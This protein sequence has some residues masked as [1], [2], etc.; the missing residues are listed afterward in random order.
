MRFCLADACD[1]LS[2]YCPVGAIGLGEAVEA[3]LNLDEF[4]R[5]GRYDFT[6]ELVRGHPLNIADRPPQGASHCALSRTLVALYRP[7][8]LI[9][10][11]VRQVIRVQQG[12]STCQ[13]T[14][15]I[16]PSLGS[17]FHPF[18]HLHDIGTAEAESQLSPSFQ[19]WRY[20]AYLDSKTGGQV[21]AQ[22]GD[23]QAHH[24]NQ[25]E[26]RNDGSE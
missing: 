14:R 1:P 6:E 16:R 19:N 20:S 25:G 23:H 9:S 13:A 5:V 22:A 11:G 12:A 7:T 17:W 26:H 21:I 24:S 3:R 10:S 15:M 8:A 4:C 2:L 18:N